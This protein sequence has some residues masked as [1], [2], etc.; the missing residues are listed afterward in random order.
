MRRSAPSDEDAA[1]LAE[2]ARRTQE[3]FVWL[4]GDARGRRLVY[5]L[6]RDAG[7]F[8]STYNPRASNASIDMACGEGRKDVGYRLLASIN[9]YAPEQYFRMMKENTND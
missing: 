4:M 5:G 1:R 8:H 9:R 6:I 2:K 3:D 7:V